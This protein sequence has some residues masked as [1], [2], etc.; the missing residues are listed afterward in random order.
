MAVLVV[1]IVALDA[2]TSTLNRAPLERRTV[3][4]K[5][6]EEAEEDSEEDAS[7]VVVIIVV[8]S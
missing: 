8:A 2:G 3:S 7:V 5:D 4:E 1:P 6:D